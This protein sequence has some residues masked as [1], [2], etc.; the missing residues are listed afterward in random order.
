MQSTYFPNRFGSK[1]STEGKQDFSIHGGMCASPY[2]N[3]AVFRQAQAIMRIHKFKS[4]SATYVNAINIPR[5][6]LYRFLSIFDTGRLLDPPHLNKEAVRKLSVL[7]SDNDKMMT[8]LWPR[9]HGLQ[10]SCWLAKGIKGKKIKIKRKM[11]RF[12]HYC[13]L[14]LVN[15]SASVMQA[16]VGGIQFPP[17][18]ENRLALFIVSIPDHLYEV[19]TVFFPLQWDSISVFTI[20]NK[21]LIRWVHESQSTL[22]CLL[23]VSNIKCLCKWG[24]A[25][26][27]PSGLVSVDAVYSHE[28]LSLKESLRKDS[29][30]ILSHY[31]M[32]ARKQ[33]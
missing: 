31:Q 32:H 19:L 8:G 18:F 24:L 1:S 25:R 13:Y 6:K 7:P 28:K 23:C 26:N 29:L 21:R 11:E 27:S 20:F 22:A 3:N 10:K 16:E 14:L 33:H 30:Y 2:V 4:Q 9:L 17:L 15:I 12:K 5:L